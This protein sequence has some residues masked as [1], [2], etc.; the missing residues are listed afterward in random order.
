MSI[1]LYLLLPL[2]ITLAGLHGLAFVARPDRLFGVA[3]AREIRYGNEGRQALRRYQLQLLPWTA[4]AMF[5][6]LW[7]RKRGR[8]PSNVSIRSDP[9]LQIPP[10]SSRTP[11]PGHSR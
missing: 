1:R 8:L 10:P 11:W 5:A 3:V 4:A 9:A 7:L 2:A 6:A